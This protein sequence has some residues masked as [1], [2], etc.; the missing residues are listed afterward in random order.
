MTKVKSANPPYSQPGSELP[1]IHYG[2]VC[3]IKRKLQTLNDV[4]L[5]YMK[6][7]Q[8]ATTLS[9]GEAQ[10]IKLA[11]LSDLIA[12]MI[13]HSPSGKSFYYSGDKCYSGY[14]LVNP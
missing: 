7:G 6:L 4:G 1:L 13:P 14:I 12:H 3:A 2:E 9:G 8:S 5:D 10:R 11:K